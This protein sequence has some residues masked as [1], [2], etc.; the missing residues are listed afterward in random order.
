MGQNQFFEALFLVELPI[1]GP[2]TPNH[3]LP[4]LSVTKGNCQSV[5]APYIPGLYLPVLSLT[6]RKLLAPWLVL[7]QFSSSGSERER[8]R[9]M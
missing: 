2:H 6:K 5:K 9:E 4:A 3:Y 1:K 7:I 8:E